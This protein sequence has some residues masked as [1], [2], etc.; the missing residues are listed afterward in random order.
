MTVIYGD[1]GD[2]DTKVLKNLWKGFKPKV[3]HAFK[4]TSEDINDALQNEKDILILCGHGSPS[5]LFGDKGYA[6]G[7]HNVDLIRAKYVIGMWCHAKE[8]AKSAHLEGFFTAMYISN[9]SEALFNL[10]EKVTVSSAEITASETEFCLHINNMIRNSLDTIKQWPEEILKIMP[11]K[12]QVEE[13]NH[14]Q[15]EYVYAD[16]NYNAEKLFS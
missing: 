10:K 3:I 12:N 7:F 14:R 11:P 4:A 6:V 13:F 8:F 15:V 5:G 9:R 1:I 2:P 16:K